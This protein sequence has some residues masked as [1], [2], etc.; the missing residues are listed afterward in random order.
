MSLNAAIEA[1]RVGEAGKGFAVVAEEIRKL[2]EQ[3]SLSTKIIN[4][5]VSELQSNTNNAVTTIDRV[6]SISIEQA[7]SV[8]NSNKKY[9]TIATAMDSSMEAIYQLSDAGEEVDLMRKSIIEV[10]ENLSAIAEENA[11]A[12]QEASASTEEQTASVEEI[13]QASDNM[14]ELAIKLNGLVTEF[15]L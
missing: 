11:A 6:A 13:A 12:T 1:A 3:S 7:G 10:L 4:D 15:K 8:D 5:I 9:E 14:S 2:A